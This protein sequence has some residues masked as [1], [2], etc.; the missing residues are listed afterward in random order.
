MWHG[1]DNEKNDKCLCSSY[2][3]MN[4]DGKMVFK[5]DFP[6]PLKIFS[7]FYDIFRVAATGWKNSILTQIIIYQRT[8]ID[9]K[10][11]QDQF[12]IALSCFCFTNCSKPGFNYKLNKNKLGFN[13]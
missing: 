13:R 8:K 12:K 5:F 3:M 10:N 6:L 4:N 7:T 9:I 11:K 1:I 2:L